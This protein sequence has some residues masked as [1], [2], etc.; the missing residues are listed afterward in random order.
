MLDGELLDKLELIARRVRNSSAVFGGLQLVLA[1]D[2]F[3]LP[4]V[5]AGDSAGGDSGG[6][7]SW[8]GGR[9]GGSNWRGRGGGRGGYGGSG[10]SSP[11][12][13][14]G[15]GG[16][17]FFFEAACWGRLV[18]A[19]VGLSQVFR[20]KD[21]RFVGL[22]NELR[23]GTVSAA[24][25][26]AIAA[27]G[28]GV[29]AAERSGMTPTRIFA[30]NRDVDAV[31]AAELAKCGGASLTFD[32]V[33]IGEEPFLGQLAANCAA[34]TQLTLKP[35]AQVI[36]LKNVDA[37]RGLVNGARG[38]VT[39]FVEQPSDGGRR[40]VLP[41]VTFGLASVGSGGGGGPVT[42][43]V[44]ESEWSVELGSRTVASRVQL[45]LKLAYALS[46]HKSQG[47]TLDLLEVSLQGVFETGQ[48]YVAL[49]RAVSLERLRVRH[50]R[51][52]LVRAHPKV[53]AFYASLASAA[54]A[55]S[56]GGGGGGAG[57][58]RG[59]PSATASSSAAAVA[60]PPAPAPTSSSGTK[61]PAFHIPQQQQ[62]QGQR[63]ASALPPPAAPAA[64]TT[65]AALAV[66]GAGHAAPAAKR[67]R[68]DA[69]TVAAPAATAKSV[70]GSGS[71][72]SAPTAPVSAAAA[73]AALTAAQ[74]MAG[75]DFSDLLLDSD[76]FF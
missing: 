25:A 65:S 74:L 23:T 57:S 11:A 58:S 5:G 24:A 6:S 56:A 43:T 10:S 27:A 61:R 20:Q 64:A 63:P 29:A 71:G 14:G 9:G 32:A 36:L 40:R 76:A 38:V 3:Q 72:A 26:A 8:R 21:P 49:S 22:L 66:A 67:P 15:G 48:A 45:P 53:V 35:G 18:Y 7:N 39:R 2:A 28:S 69:P 55:A 1:G 34:P 16:A 62:Q 37:E 50:F 42:T 17:R 73:A 52:D 44:E 13:G 4:P 46:I 51:P 30:L 60:A 54:A 70:S 41:E 19:C 68:S 31:N 75:D 33:D 59:K 47:M 12:A